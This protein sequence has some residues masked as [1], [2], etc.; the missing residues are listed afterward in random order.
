M[1]EKRDGLVTFATVWTQPELH[2]L[3]G[4]LAANDI[5]A[6]AAGARHVSV[7]P[8]LGIALGGMRVRIHREDLA[9]AVDVVAEVD[10]TPYCGPLFSRNRIVNALAVLLLVLTVCPAPA[11]I[12]ARF[13]FARRETEPG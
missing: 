8:D 10:R 12:P 4:L 5:W 1:D 9:L 7:E 2:S 13:H 11:R 6:T 3:L